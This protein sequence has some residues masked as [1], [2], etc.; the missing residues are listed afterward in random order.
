[1]ALQKGIQRKN[2]GKRRG[3]HH[4]KKAS[5]KTQKSW[6]IAGAKECERTRKREKN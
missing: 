6:L 1:M 4:G 2:I 3:D 5:A